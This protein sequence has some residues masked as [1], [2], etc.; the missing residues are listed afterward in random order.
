VQTGTA[1]ID[2]PAPVAVTEARIVQV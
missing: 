1:A 2:A